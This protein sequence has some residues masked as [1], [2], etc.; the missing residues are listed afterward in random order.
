MARTR[1]VRAPFRRSGSVYYGGRAESKVIPWE[2]VV[3]AVFDLRTYR[4]E[5]PVQT[6]RSTQ[7]VGTPHQ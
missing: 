7:E 6:L 5:Q 2:D 4:F 3:V 1:A